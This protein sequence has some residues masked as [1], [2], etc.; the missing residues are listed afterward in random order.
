MKAINKK[1]MNMTGFYGMLMIFSFIRAVGT[2]IFIVPNGFA[3][4]G[5]SGLSS[6]IYNIVLASNATLAN[7]VFNP[8]V[9]SL[10]FNI[11]LLFLA[12]RYLNKK[13]ALNTLLAVIAFSLFMGLFTLVDFPMFKANTYESGIMLLASLAGG[14]VVGIALGYMLRMN[15]SLGGTDIV[16]K[17]I[18]KKKPF[19]NV[20]WLI[21]ICDCSI[22]MLS[23]VLGFIDIRG[24]DGTQDVLVKVLSPVFYSFIA[25]FVC[26]KVADVILVGLESSVVFNIVTKHPQEIGDAVINN[27]KRGATIIKGAGVYTKKEREIL[28]CVIK[29][30]QIIPLKKLIK[31]IDPESFS[32]VT[33]AKEVNGFGFYTGD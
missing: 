16:A 7:S 10:L 20:Q 13:F 3:P 30:K 12:F 6:I 15:M 9:T 29:R 26:S 23:A 31:E 28:I 33:S 2:Y 18:Y 4:G 24:G 22:V 1:I 19:I 32:Y 17:I 14:S 27:L 21:F 8:A 25:L 5:I 11:P